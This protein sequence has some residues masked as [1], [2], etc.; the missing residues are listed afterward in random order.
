MK[1]DLRGRFYVELLLCMA[2]SEI[3]FTE[4]NDLTQASRR[5]ISFEFPEDLNPSLDDICFLIKGLYQSNPNAAKTFIQSFARKNSKLFRSLAVDQSKSF[6]QRLYILPKK[7]PT[8]I[9]ET[10]SMYN[11][12]YS[13]SI[14]EL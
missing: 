11:I 3:K 7:L 8:I 10:A 6:D 9:L 5:L 4:Y 1:L 12:D 2:I 13:P 14:D